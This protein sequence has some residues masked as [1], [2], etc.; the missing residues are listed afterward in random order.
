MS[1]VSRRAFLG[2]AGLAAGGVAASGA[3]LGLLGACTGSTDEQ[4]GVPPVPLDPNDWDSVR[5]QFALSPDLLQFSAFVL[6]S[7]P[8][9]VTDAITKHRTRLDEDTVGYLNR[10]EPALD[11]AVLSAAAGYLETEPD[12]IALTDSTT[13]GL[14]LIYGGLRM[15]PGQEVLTTDQDFY[16]THEALQMRAARDDVTVRMVKLYDYAA[17]ASVDEIVSRL[18]EALAPS[19]RAVA[20][21]WVHSGTGVKLPVAEISAEIHTRASEM[22]IERPL[23]CLDSVHGFGI[24]DSSPAELGC[25]FMISGAHKW[26]FGPRGTGLVWGSIESW[27]QIDTSI[28]SFAPGIVGAY[29]QDL[30]PVGVAPGAAATPGG[31]KAFEQRWALSEAFALHQAIGRDRIAERTHEQARQ[32]KAGLAELNSVRVVTPRDPDLSSGIVCLAV[33]GASIFELPARL[34]EQ[35]GL[36]ASITPYRQPY[37]RL[38]PSL[39]TSP[40]DVEVAIEAIDMV[41]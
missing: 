4:V 31:Y 19:T 14:G 16:S 29:L 39:L 7:P 11:S 27:E 36:V 25:D 8:R 18:R 23:L 21:T 41:R 17:T 22:G 1:E 20:L 30:P 28:P 10:E 35:Y 34:R 5:G 33:E 12:T 3:A 2:R 24:E 37:L 6:A 13:M 26:L 32:L 40:D 15:S 9:Q 38:G